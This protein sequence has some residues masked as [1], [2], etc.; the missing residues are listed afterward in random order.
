M[1][2]ISDQPIVGFY[3]CYVLKNIVT[4]CIVNVACKAVRP[5]YNM[6]VHV[7]LHQ[8]SMVLTNGVCKVNL[9][10]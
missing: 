4:S 3:N 1:P 5:R 10:S 7:S 6:Y 8:N 2:C 9:P